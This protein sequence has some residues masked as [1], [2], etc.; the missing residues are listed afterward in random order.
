VRADPV[1]AAGGAATHAEATL[2]R[3]IDA[4]PLRADDPQLLELARITQLAE[5]DMRVAEAAGFCLSR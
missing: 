5:R 2:Q 3:Y 1:E 4:G